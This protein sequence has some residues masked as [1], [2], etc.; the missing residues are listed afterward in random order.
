MFETYTNGRR[1]E[2]INWAF[3]S[4][5]AVIQVCG[6]GPGSQID[7]FFFFFLRKMLFTR[8]YKLEIS[9]RATKLEAL[10]QIPAVKIS[11]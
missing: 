11:V 4:L 3:C 10:A 7:F 9:T 6:K 2:I 1:K 8:F 5:S